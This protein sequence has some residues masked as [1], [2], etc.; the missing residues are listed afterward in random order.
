LAKSYGIPG[1]SGLAVVA[2]LA[3]ILIYRHRNAKKARVTDNTKQI[4][5][6]RLGVTMQVVTLSMDSERKVRLR[7]N[8]I[9]SPEGESREQEDD[10]VNCVNPIS[11]NQHDNENSPRAPRIT[12]VEF[13]SEEVAR[14]KAWSLVSLNSPTPQLTEQEEGL[15]VT[16]LKEIEKAR[17]SRSQ[18]ITLQFMRWKASTLGDVPPLVQIRTKIADEA[19]T[20]RDVEDNTQVDVTNKVHAMHHNR[21]EETLP[22]ESKQPKSHSKTEFEQVRIENPEES[23]TVV[24]KDVLSDDAVKLPV[25][26]RVKRPQSTRRKAGRR[27]KK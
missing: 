9:I 17:L 21:F 7:S 2:L 5:A 8:G 10:Q 20:E 23:K 4:Y 19:D 26:P 14:H 15:E 11:Q 27:F 25:L 13:E 18:K 1:F 6:E 24:R 22:P 3:V 16:N 12:Y